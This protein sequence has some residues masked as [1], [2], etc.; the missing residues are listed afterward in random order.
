MYSAEDQSPSKSIVR[1]AEK[2]LSSKLSL[3]VGFAT[4]CQA[5]HWPSQDRSPTAIEPP[6]QWL[7]GR[8]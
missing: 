4:H 2:G 6:L 7:A 8:S 3:L 5:H 1:Y